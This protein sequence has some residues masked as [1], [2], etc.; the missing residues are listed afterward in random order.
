MAKGQPE[1]LGASFSEKQEKR[2]VGICHLV[3][4]KGYRRPSL[5]SFV[6]VDAEVLVKLTSSLI[7]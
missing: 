7:W 4:G 2:V 3:A 5:G 6:R 1:T